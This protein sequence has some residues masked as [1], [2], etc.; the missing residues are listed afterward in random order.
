MPTAFLF[1]DSVEADVEGVE[2]TNLIVSAELI[3][4]AAFA[5]T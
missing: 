1:H 5:S 4:F 2:A 3:Y